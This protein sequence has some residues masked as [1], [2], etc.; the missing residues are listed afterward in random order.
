M[1]RDKQYWLSPEQSSFLLE[2][3]NILGTSKTEVSIGAVLKL[4][5]YIDEL[6]KKNKKRIIFYRWIVVLLLLLLIIL[7]FL[8]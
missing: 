8:R 2:I 5:I 3:H 7:F 1:K 4:K 6:N